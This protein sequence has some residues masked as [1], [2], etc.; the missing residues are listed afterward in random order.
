MD[1]VEPTYNIKAT[2]STKESVEITVLSRECRRKILLLH[3]CIIFFLR[4]KGSDKGL[5]KTWLFHDTVQDSF[6]LYVPLPDNVTV[7]MIQ[8]K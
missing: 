8:S 3:M 6:K 5:V 1:Y 7:R 2:Y 4:V